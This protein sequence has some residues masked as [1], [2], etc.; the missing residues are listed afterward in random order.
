[1]LP[2]PEKSVLHRVCGALFAA[3]AGL[4]Y[5]TKNEYNKANTILVFYIQHIGVKLCVLI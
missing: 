5:R 3:P 1:M 4:D 2:L